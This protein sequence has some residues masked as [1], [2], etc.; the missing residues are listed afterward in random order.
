VSTMVRSGSA[1]ENRVARPEPTRYAEGVRALGL[2]VSVILLGSSAGCRREVE[3]P[4]ADA[5]LPAWADGGPP[6]AFFETPD[7]P[8]PDANEDA[9]SE[10]AAASVGALIER[11]PVDIIW[12]VDNSSSMAPAIAEVQSGMDAFARRLADS[13]LDYRL[14]LL[15]LRGVGETTVAGSRRFQVCVPEPVAGPGCADNAPRFFQVEVDIKSTQP[16]EQVLGTLAQSA[17]YTVGQERGGPPWLDLLRPEAT[18]SFVLVSDDNA[19]LCGGPRGCDITAGSPWTCGVAGATPFDQAT[20][21]E[22]Y[23]GGASPFSSTVQLGPGILTRAYDLPDTGP[24]FEGYVFNAIYGWGSDT[25]DGVACGECGISGAIVS[26]PGPTYSALVRH[27][28][29]VR[30]QICDGPAAWAP[31][32]ESVANRVVETSRID[33]EVAIPPPP[34]G[35]FFLADRVNVHLRGR[36]RG[37]AAGGVMGAPACN[38]TTGGWYYDA[39][40]M[41]TSITLCPAT[42][43]VAR[44]QVTTPESG[45]EVR[46]GCDSVPG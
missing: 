6:D 39:E 21:F 20:D 4:P 2:A 10:C 26:S 16:L 22:T 34:D 37:L 43:E 7:A 30:A 41:P 8:R 31:F 14:I 3:P 17:G 36:A 11:L 46:F 9:S 32:F 33:C 12:V 35:M 13:D 18:K 25:D 15:S 29:G 1:S 24:L 28:G 38:P 42:C 45:V 44:E 27:T 19:R 40:A 5:P 23:P